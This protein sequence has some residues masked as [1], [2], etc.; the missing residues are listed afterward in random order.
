MG[1]DIH[2]ISQV[3]KDGKWQ[4]AEKGI[5]DERSYMLFGVLAGVR[6][7]RFDPIAEPKG[8]PSDLEYS[9]SPDEPDDFTIVDDFWLGDHS[10]THLTLTELFEYD[11]DQETPYKDEYG[12]AIKLRDL[13]FFKS[14]VQE[15]LIP[16]AEENGGPNNVRIVFGFDS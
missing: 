10:H 15:Q 3:K 8:I 16:L 9:Q 1:C 11:W 7:N 14:V 6:D 5:Y 4:I 13:H 12:H 2:M